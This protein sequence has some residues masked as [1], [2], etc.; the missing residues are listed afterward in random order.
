ML[1]LTSGLESEHLIKLVAAF[2][3]KNVDCILLPYYTTNLDKF[4]RV[5]AYSIGEKSVKE[6]QAACTHLLRQMKGI[7]E[8]LD[9]MQSLPDDPILHLDVCSQNILVKFPSSSKSEPQL[10]LTDFDH[11]LPRSK[12]MRMC[13]AGD[14]RNDQLLDGVDELLSNGVT[15]PRTRLRALRKLRRQSTDHSPGVRS[16]DISPPPSPGVV[17]EEDGL[18]LG[19]PAYQPPHT[20]GS[21]SEPEFWQKYDVFSF[22]VVLLEVLAFLQGGSDL[23]CKLY[24]ARAP[25]KKTARA[26]WDGSDGIFRPT[27][28]MG[29]FLGDFEAGLQGSALLK[30]GFHF[31]LTSML[32]FRHIATIHSRPDLKWVLLNWDA[33][34]DRDQVQDRQLGSIVKP[35]SSLR[36]SQPTASELLPSSSRLMGSPLSCTVECLSLPHPTYYSKVNLNRAADEK[37]ILVWASEDNNAIKCEPQQE[38]L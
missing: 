15:R 14:P 11:S 25:Q 9:L 3:V 18:R 4:M 13:G 36:L 5:P 16:Q 8:A 29:S 20:N 26:I 7:A 38:C 24:V 31:V 30:S 12:V 35:A 32:R 23:V 19:K 37:T 1:S 10:V 21:L 33:H 2:T 28:E 22:G 34:F 17:S 6:K 27:S